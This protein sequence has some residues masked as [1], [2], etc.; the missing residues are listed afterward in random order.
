M[1]PLL[2]HISQLIFPASCFACQ[3]Q[4]PSN[5]FFLCY[6]CNTSMP[7]IGKYAANNFTEKILWGRAPFLFADSLLY[8]Q[9]EGLAQKVIHQLKYK[10]QAQVGEWLGIQM[11]KKI[12]GMPAHLWQNAIL[13]PVPLSPKRQQQ[14]GYNQSME[15]ALGIQQITQLS[16]SENGILRLHNTETQTRKNRMDRLANMKHAFEADSKQASNTAHVILVDDVIT[17][18]A[19]LESCASAIIA[20]SSTTKVSIVAAAIAM[21]L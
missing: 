9:K 17:T 5:H 2:H 15:I 14:R 4:L 18:G 7:Y 8:F 1:H 12:K 10:N 3:A 13:V 16:I 6:A 20:N 11:G 21:N 19:T